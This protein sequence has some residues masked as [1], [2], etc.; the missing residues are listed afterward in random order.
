MVFQQKNINPCFSMIY[1]FQSQDKQTYDFV[2]TL[3]KKNKMTV[4][5]GMLSKVSFINIYKD[6]WIF[7]SRVV[8]TPYIEF[9]VIASHFPAYK[10]VMPIDEVRDTVSFDGYTT[11]TMIVKTDAILKKLSFNKMS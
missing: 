11:K 7:L 8:N 6:L 5:H 9:E 3:E 10:L 4:I 2:L 1:G